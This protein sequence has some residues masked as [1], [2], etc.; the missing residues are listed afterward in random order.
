MSKN[1][2]NFMSKIRISTTL[3]LMVAFILLTSSYPVPETAS[4]S[5]PKGKN[6]LE[7]TNLTVGEILSLSKSEFR[8]LYG[9][10]LSF[11]EAFV[12][13]SFQ[14]DLRKELNDK[15]ITLGQTLNFKEVFEEK[16][17]EFNIG[18]F[19]LGFLLGLIGVGLAHI[20]STDKNFRRSSWQG[21]GAWVI[22]LL[23]IAAVA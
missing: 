17:F 20:F 2:P 15:K 8:E 5:H 1:K 10:K 21:L 19:V 7:L 18:G 13:K 11:K 14:R 16:K 22:L 3:T 4:F 9:S 23:V 6:N 12:F